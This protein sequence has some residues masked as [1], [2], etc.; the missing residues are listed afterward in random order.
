MEILQPSAP[1]DEGQASDTWT[2]ALNVRD[3]VFRGSEC[4]EDV[5]TLT[6]F[7]F[8]V[9]KRFPDACNSWTSQCVRLLLLLQL[10]IESF[11]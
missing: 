2:F 8:N 10:P 9:K 3:R 6:L 4:Q 1:E 11:E 5:R 7:S